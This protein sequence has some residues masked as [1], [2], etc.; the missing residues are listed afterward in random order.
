MRGPQKKRGKRVSMLGSNEPC[1]YNYQC[2]TECCLEPRRKKGRR[3]DDSDSDS[4][5]DDRRVLQSFP[6]KK[7]VSGEY[8]DRFGNKICVAE[9]RCDDDDDGYTI[10]QFFAGLIMGGLCIAVTL[11]GWFY[12]KEVS[13]AQT[14][15]NQNSAAFQMGPV[16]V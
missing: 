4:E 3:G 12:R 13:N 8:N 5:D 9:R 1:N 16:P 14:Q 15:A 6:G 11:Q 7:Q 10:W 2:E